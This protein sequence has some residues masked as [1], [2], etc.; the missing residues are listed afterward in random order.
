MFPPV[1]QNAEIKFTDDH[2]QHKNQHSL[3]VY[4]ATYFSQLGSKLDENDQ[5]TPDTCSFQVR[6]NYNFGFGSH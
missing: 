4:T 5:S 6:I 1:A 2:F 3:H